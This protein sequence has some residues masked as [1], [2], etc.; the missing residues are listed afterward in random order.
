MNE[1]LSNLRVGDKV[2]VSNYGYKEIAQ[3]E[4]ITPS[5]MIKVNG[6]LYNKD[7]SRRG[8]MYSFCLQECT[9]E[10]EKE[11][12][13]RAFIRKVV[14]RMRNIKDITYEQAIKINRILADDQ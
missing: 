4:K 5:G 13:Q 3:I 2:I 12:A 10:I 7:G 11:L 9:P 1:W 6:S 8:A 14:T